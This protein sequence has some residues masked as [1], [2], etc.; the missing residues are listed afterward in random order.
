MIGL[1]LYFDGIIVEW[2]VRVRDKEWVL[3][4][5]LDEIER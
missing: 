5:E 2:E 4:R 3:K 1:E